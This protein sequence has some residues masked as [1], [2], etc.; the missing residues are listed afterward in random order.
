[1][2][3]TPTIISDNILITILSSDLS[4][5]TLST[6]MQGFLLSGSLTTDDGIGDNILII[7]TNLIDTSYIA[8]PD[9][10]YLNIPVNTVTGN[11]TGALVNVVV[12][13]GG[14]TEVGVINGGSG[15]VIGDT[16]NIAE[17]TLQSFGIITVAGTLTLKTLTAA[18][19]D[20]GGTPYMLNF[21]PS[22][23]SASLGVV[24]ENQKLLVG[25]P[26][27]ALYHA[28]N[29][30]V[31]QS[32]YNTNLLQTINNNEGAG[33]LL[34]TTSGSDA[35]NSNNYM[36][37]TPDGSDAESYQD[38]NT[39]FSVERGDIIRVEGIK[40][41]VNDATNSSASLNII[42]DFTV[43]EIVPYYYSSSFDTNL[44]TKHGLDFTIGPYNDDVPT[45]NYGYAVTFDGATDISTPPNTF[46]G[47]IGGVGG[48]GA[49]GGNLGRLGSDVKV[50]GGT[51]YSGTYVVGVIYPVQSVSPAGGT[52]ATIK[53][54]TVD[55][56]G[57]PTSVEMATPGSGYSLADVLSFG[58]STIPTGATYTITSAVNFLDQ[59][60]Q[61]YRNNALIQP[62]N[63]GGKVVISA[64][65]T[66]QPLNPSGYTHIYLSEGSNFLVGDVIR[67]GADSINDRGQWSTYPAA[68]TTIMAGASDYMEITLEQQMFDNDNFNNDFT[69]GVDTNAQYSYDPPTYPNVPSGSVAGYHLYEKGEVRFIA[70]TFLRV[71]PNPVTTLSGLLDGEV[72]KFT[73]RR[74]IEADDKVML[75]NIN[76]PSGSKGIET[77][78]GQGFLIP[79]DFSP[80]QKSNA[81][82]IINQLKAKNAFDK[83]NEPGIT[84][85]GSGGSSSGN[86]FGGGGEGGIQ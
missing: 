27:L 36:T 37:W 22:P 8:S 83:P 9:G 25:G 64:T 13:S 40:N 69:I 15:Y 80:V 72:K 44:Q 77:P 52:G 11:G 28:Y 34:W 29:S 54:L 65:N 2:G 79:N 57:R 51:G 46:T 62:W 32:L 66:G 78:S 35:A 49:G 10:T 45:D 84:D 31:S 1:M 63:N 70:N 5:S 42:E 86:S 47:Y 6:T 58:G 60:I 81:L 38:T 33:T 48:F 85:I 14:I 16:I 7:G 19:L 21:N 59:K 50:N 26:Q 55:G 82:N 20:G 3:G 17:A 23:V 30:T 76:P 61:V 24:P 74:Q 4:T 53:V 68:I 39:P 18:D 56:F 75:K 67:I 71:T 12:R 43:E 41:I 73:V